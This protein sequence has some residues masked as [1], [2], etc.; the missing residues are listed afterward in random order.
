MAKIKIK[1][2]T[3]KVIIPFSTDQ[4]GVH[5]LQLP[6][7]QGVSCAGGPAGGVLPH[8]P[9]LP[10]TRHCHRVRRAVWSSQHY[11]QTRQMSE[12]VL[13]FVNYLL[14]ES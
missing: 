2:Y 5:H 3:E 14:S 6:G 11:C 9:P 10:H 1:I 8:D 13:M 12:A 4:R 7:G